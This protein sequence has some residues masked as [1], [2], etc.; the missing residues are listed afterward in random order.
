MQKSTNILD[1][2][3][4]RVHYDIIPSMENE[5]DW[6]VRINE[7]F[8]ETI[9]HFGAIEFTGKNADDPDG[10]ISF[11]FKIV[12][13]PDPELSINDLTLQ[14]YSGRILNSILEKSA[15]DGGLVL[16]NSK[17]QI[18]TKKMKER[19]EKEYNADEH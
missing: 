10:N 18:M 16:E 8:P 19:L 1:T 14:Q 17:G 6:H 11:N 3:S 4:E 13:T 2:L 12:S 7:E 15:R 9:I 5:T